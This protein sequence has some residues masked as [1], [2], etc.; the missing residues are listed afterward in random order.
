[1]RW[2]WAAA[3]P[4]NQISRATGRKGFS[5]IAVSQTDLRR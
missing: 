1:V 4:L 2:Y 3:S 5:V